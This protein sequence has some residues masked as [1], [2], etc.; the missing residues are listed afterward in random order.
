MGAKTN[1][2]EYFEKLKGLLET[3]KSIF[4]VT[5]DNVSFR[6]TC[7]R[8]VCLSWMRSANYSLKTGLFT[9]NARDP[10][11]S[12]RSRCCSHGKEYYGSPCYPC[13]AL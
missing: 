4:I 12:K 11:L 6:Q 9:A 10:C 13:L 3:Y 8:W 1:K 7:R 2:V 5:V